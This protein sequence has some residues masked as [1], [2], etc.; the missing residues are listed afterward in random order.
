V[1]LQ[2]IEQSNCE[3]EQ[4]GAGDGGVDAQAAH[5][6][7]LMLAS[8]RVLARCAAVA[9][10]PSPACAPGSRVVAACLY[11]PPCV[12]PGSPCSQDQ[13]HP[14]LPACLPACLP[15]PPLP[16]CARFCAEVPE[17]FGERLRPLLPSL[18]ALRSGPAN[19]EWDLELLEEGEG[20]PPAPAG[21]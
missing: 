21:E 19:V 3:E 17:V 10:P 6:Q 18:L 11:T 12:V 7:P 4:G 13:Q 8:L 16:P 2:F 14:C 1:V 9:G 5:H 15:L 20:P